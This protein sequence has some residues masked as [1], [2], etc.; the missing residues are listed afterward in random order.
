MSHLALAERIADDLLATGAVVL[1]PDEPF[2]WSSGLKSPIYCDNR[3]T[4]SYPE[5]RERIAE[6]FA[7]AIRARFPETALI[8]GAATGGIPHA[9]WTSQKLNLPMIYVRDKPKGHGK[10]NMIEGVL[11]PGQKTVVIEDLVS[12][13]GSSLKVAE[14]VREAGGD[15]LA[16]LAI[17]TYKLPKAEQTFAAAG[18][19]LLTLTDYDVLIGR[20]LAGGRI[21]SDQLEL[22]RA[23]RQNPESFGK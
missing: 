23:W 15:V 14:A 5:V 21:G 16:V 3:I 13:G 17:F 1:R 19:P 6:G 7:A 8:A 9:A 18:I 2:T 12:T 20:A 11:V 4:I 10:Q 22:L